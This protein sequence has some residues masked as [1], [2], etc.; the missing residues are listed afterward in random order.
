MQ[1]NSNEEG[2]RFVTASYKILSFPAQVRTAVLLFDYHINY[3]VLLIN[4]RSIILYILF[5]IY[6]YF[7]EGFQAIEHFGGYIAE[8]S[9]KLAV[10]RQVQEDEKS[11]LIEVRNSLKNSPGLEKLVSNNLT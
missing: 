11:D 3:K 5:H 7:S 4:Y 1:R 8:L 6:R 9:G 10:I 2:S